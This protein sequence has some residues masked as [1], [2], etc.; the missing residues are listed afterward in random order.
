[1]LLWTDM[2]RMALGYDYRRRGIME[3]HS[4]SRRA[5]RK[6]IGKSGYGRR[7][8]DARRKVAK[9]VA[10]GLFSLI[11][12]SILPPTSPSHVHA[13]RPLWAGLLWPGAGR[14]PSSG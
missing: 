4:G 10:A 12:A 5:M 11:R 14:A 8:E 9:I 6:V 1:Y 3:R 7:K 2:R 13:R